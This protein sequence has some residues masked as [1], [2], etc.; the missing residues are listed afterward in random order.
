MGSRVRSDYSHVV[1]CNRKQVSPSSNYFND[2]GGLPELSG[3]R[4]TS[5]R[6][7]RSS[8]TKRLNGY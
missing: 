8:T 1:S 2:V 3:A 7:L 6:G 4:P 5:R